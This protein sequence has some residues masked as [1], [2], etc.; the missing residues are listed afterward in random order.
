MFQHW[1]TMV[2]YSQGPCF[3]RDSISELVREGPNKQ[4]SKSL[5]MVKTIQHGDATRSDCSMEGLLEEVIFHL[6]LDKKEP[7]M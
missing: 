2:G 7:T 4:M 6:R 5:L 3:C 1:V